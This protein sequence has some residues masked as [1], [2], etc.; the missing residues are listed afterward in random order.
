MPTLKAL[1]YRVEYEGGP[2]PGV[3]QRLG[4]FHVTPFARM[5]QGSAAR[6]SQARYRVVGRA[7]ERYKGVGRGLPVHSAAQGGLPV[8]K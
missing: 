8:C 4:A 5:V 6:L 7:L 2:R 3:E 1:A